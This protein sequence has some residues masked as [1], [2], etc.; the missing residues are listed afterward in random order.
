MTPASESGFERDILD[1]PAA[2]VAYAAQPLPPGI[3]ELDVRAFE[4]IIMTGMG[5]SD[6]LTLGLELLLARRCLPVWRIQTSH[7]LQAPEWITPETLLWITSQSG[8]S[9]EV[10]ALLERLAAHRPRAIVAVTN[11]PA[12]PLGRAADH[13]ILLHSG[14]EATVSSKSYLNSLGVFH[15]I[16]AMVEG[17]DDATAAGELHDL[18]AT[19]RPATANAPAAVQRLVTQALASPNPRFALVGSGEDATTALTGA[20]IMKEA[21]KVAAEGYLGGAF[22]HGPLE[23]AGPGLTALLFGSEQEDITLSVLARDLAATGSTVVSIGPLALDGAEHI[24]VSAGPAVSRLAHA[25]VFLQHLSVALARAGGYVPGA[26]RY[27]KKIT[28]QV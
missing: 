13:C 14:A 20:L 16:A 18:A 19:L 11:D 5:S 8:R 9:G 26:F 22:R 10:V 23:L 27:G 6:Y 1:Q 24:P 15:R 7:L 28:A 4:R 25:M 21:A 17:R 2:L 12:S 3:A